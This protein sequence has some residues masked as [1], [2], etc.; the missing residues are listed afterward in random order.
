MK[1]ISATIIGFA[2]ALSALAEQPKVSPDPVLVALKDR[3]E[4]EFQKLDPKPTFEFPDSCGGRTLAVRFKTR[5]YVVHPRKPK[6]SFVETTVKREGPTYQGFYLRIHVQQ[7]GEV[8]QLCVPQVVREPYWD[9]YL[10]VYPV[11]NT[12]K[13]LYFCLF[14]N[15]GTDKALL[16]QIKK[17]AEQ[18]DAGKIKETFH[19]LGKPGDPFSERIAKLDAERTRLTVLVPGKDQYNLFC[20][21]FDLGRLPHPH[22]VRISR[23]KMSAV[24]RVLAESGNYDWK[25]MTA[26]GYPGSETA[27][28][29]YGLSAQDHF[30]C[31]LGR[32]T[33]SVKSLER[34]ISPLKGRARRILQQAVTSL[35]NAPVRS[36]TK[37]PAAE[38][39]GAAAQPT[40]GFRLLSAQGKPILTDAD[41]VAYSWPTHT[42]ILKPGVVTKLKAELM[43]KL[44]HSFPFKVEADG[45]I[46]YQGVFTT[47]ESSIPQSC[48][49]INLN[50]I[51]KPPAERKDRLS[52]TL[53][54]PSE[55][56][57]RGKD[58]RG[59]PR[60]RAALVALGKLQD[61]DTKSSTAVFSQG[62]DRKPKNV[63]MTLARIADSE[64][65][66]GKDYIFVING[67]VAYRT[68]DGLKKYLKELP[69][70]STLTW[71]PGCGRMG[72][73]PLLSSKEEMQKF[74]A[75][76]ESCGISFV[77]VPSG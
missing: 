43:S 13:Q 14:Y 77:L 21:K 47:S 40:A 32:G 30:Q 61:N 33:E 50:P 23:E 51:G 18:T 63:T 25:P 62:E 11:K 20:G 15:K 26:V 37:A 59:D 9:M 56:F 8:N 28:L 55:K 5:N 16:D 66:D 22:D 65:V 71:A 29:L 58:P 54:Y 64:R 57:F 72:G 42:L 4:H 34:L 49:V 39:A 6:G 69:K 38:T 46:C 35:K 75:F 70:G 3:L 27:L 10:D 68:L 44:S 60:I 67:V 17:V 73:E 53:G 12:Q 1:T 31:S 36:D 48:A 2:L 74:K 7:L 52:I 45:V 41:I 76:C 19:F 24:L